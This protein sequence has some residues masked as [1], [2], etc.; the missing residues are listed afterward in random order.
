MD[1]PES[2]SAAEAYPIELQSLASGDQ[3]SFLP[4]PE[5]AIKP[6]KFKSW[7]HRHLTGWKFGVTVSAIAA[8]TVFVINLIATIFVVSRN[9]GQ[10]S[11]DGRAL[12][13]GGSCKMSRKINI[14]LHVLINLLSTAL[15]GG[16]NYSMQCL[17][18]PT[19]A[20]VD[21]WHR[22]SKRGKSSWL[23]IGVHSPRNLTRIS[24]KRAL[25]WCCLC[26][27]SI[28]LHLL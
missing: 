26:I 3:D 13:Y 8:T 23:D 18:A 12:F 5:S 21:K 14:G 25:L 9:N 17:S 24:K 15:L 27:S 11:D 6:N 16:S 20:E 4:H 1:D 22:S 2:C 19:R 7:R 10:I 28:P